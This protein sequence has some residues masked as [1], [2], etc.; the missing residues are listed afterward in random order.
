MVSAHDDVDTKPPSFKS[1]DGS[2]LNTMKASFHT[3]IACVLVNQVKTLVDLWGL[4]LVYVL[5][6]LQG[7][8]SRAF[9]SVK[10][11]L[12]CDHSFPPALQTLAYLELKTG[13]TCQLLPCRLILTPSIFHLLQGNVQ[14]ALYTLKHDA[15]SPNSVFRSVAT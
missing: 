3:N 12:C 8:F 11:A 6:V 2:D 5:S 9:S 7:E 4:K 10:S 13:S 14:A 1:K 15:L